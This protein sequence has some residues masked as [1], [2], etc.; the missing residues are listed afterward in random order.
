MAIRIQLTLQNNFSA[1]DKK[2]SL[3]LLSKL[4]KTYYLIL[5]LSPLTVLLLIAVSSIVRLSAHVLSMS[6]ETALYQL[7]VLLRITSSNQKK[8]WIILHWSLL[9]NSNKRYSSSR[10]SRTLNRNNYNNISNK[11]SPV[12]I[13]FF[14]AL[15]DKP[16]H[17]KLQIISRIRFLKS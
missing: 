11:L 9:L 5:A 1:L 14:I 13:K 4:N 7:I 2:F 12:R 3:R 8:C 10:D 6:V 16:Y 17:L 15:L